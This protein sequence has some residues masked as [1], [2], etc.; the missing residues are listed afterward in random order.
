MISTGTNTQLLSTLISSTP[1]NTVRR[2]EETIIP[3]AIPP[4]LAAP[5]G[6]RSEIV[7]SNSPIPTD[8]EVNLVRTNNTFQNNYSVHNTTNTFNTSQTDQLASSFINNN[9]NEY[10]NRS[11]D[12]NLI[13]QRQ[14]AFTEQQQQNRIHTI[15]HQQQSLL[16]E[17][18]Q[19][20]IINNVVHQQPPP[21]IVRKT[22]PNNV[23][24]YEQNVSVRYLK[25]PTPPPPG[26][27]IIRKSQFF[28][29]YFH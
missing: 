11:I 13:H 6:W 16:T 9:N 14:S 1:T 23:V 2:I 7:Y 22:L 25:P 21:V 3:Q 4:P 27:L 29:Y 19:Q 20:R 28:L 18:Q 17:Q 10:I 15:E 26:P 8:T 12:E 5:A 24:T